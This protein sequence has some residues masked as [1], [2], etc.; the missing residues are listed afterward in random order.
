MEGAFG[1]IFKD[2][3]LRGSFLARIRMPNGKF[4]NF[5]AF[6][7]FLNLIRVGNCDINEDDLSSLAEFIACLKNNIGK[8]NIVAA[9]SFQ[10]IGA[11]VRHFQ[12]V[13]PKDIDLR[14]MKLLGENDG[15]TLKAND[16]GTRPFMNIHGALTEVH[17]TVKNTE[18]MKGYATIV[19]MA[20]SS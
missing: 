17:D 12:M 14:Y 15:L 6:L 13:L 10:S 9:K 7:K 2:K 11:A 20:L 8:D 3:S 19:Q 1:F 16:G 5:V 4:S 18:M